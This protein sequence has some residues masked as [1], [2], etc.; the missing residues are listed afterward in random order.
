MVSGLSRVCAV[1]VGLL[2]G[3]DLP[4]LL[5]PILLLLAGW[6]S[7]SNNV[8]GPSPHQTSSHSSPSLHALC[9]VSGKE[10]GS[11]PTGYAPLPLPAPGEGG[12]PQWWNAGGWSRAARGEREPGCPFL[13]RQRPQCRVDLGH[14]EAETAGG[15]GAALHCA[16]LPV[17]PTAAPAGHL[18]GGQQGVPVVAGRLRVGA[19]ARGRWAWA[20]TQADA[21]GRHLPVNLGV[22]CCT[23]GFQLG[24]P[25]T[26]VSPNLWPPVFSRWLPGAL[27]VLASERGLASPP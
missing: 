22:R 2:Q 7:C 9:S 5:L 25:G 12:H 1:P 20:G 17:G 4:R 24:H 21:L 14:P 23:L 27:P 13:L 3:P 19:G 8:W 10:Q 26:R 16:R 18:H 15:A 11:R 6:T